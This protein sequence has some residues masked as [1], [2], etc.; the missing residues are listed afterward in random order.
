MIEKAVASVFVNSCFTD[1]PE[2]VDVDCVSSFI[3]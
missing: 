2:K 3:L 1:E